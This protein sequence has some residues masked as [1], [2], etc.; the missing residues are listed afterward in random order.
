MFY[1]WDSYYNSNNCIEFNVSDPLPVG[2]VLR[3]VD[4]DGIPHFCVG[5]YCILTAEYKPGSMGARVDW[6]S[7]LAGDR[8]GY[9]DAGGLVVVRDED[10]ADLPDWIPLR[11][12]QLKNPVEGTCKL[13]GEQWR[14]VTEPFYLED[15]ILAA[16]DHK[17]PRMG[18]KTV[19]CGASCGEESD[20]SIKQADAARR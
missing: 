17:A 9:G 5:A 2:T 3:G 1:S 16:Q 8:F 20:L 15:P 12:E 10:L 18:C 11:Q 4:S 6:G 19:C 13:C 7:R 14:G